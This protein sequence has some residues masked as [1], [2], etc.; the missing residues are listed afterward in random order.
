MSWPAAEDSGANAV[1]EAT[2]SVAMSLPCPPLLIPWRQC[3]QHVNNRATAWCQRKSLY[4]QD[5]LYVLKW[6]VQQ[7]RAVLITVIDKKQGM[8]M[9]LLQWLLTSYSHL[10]PLSYVLSRSGTTCHTARW[11]CIRSTWLQLKRCLTAAWFNGWLWHQLPWRPNH[12]F[13][14]ANAAV[15]LLEE[16]HQSATMKTSMAFGWGPTLSWNVSINNT[17]S[18]LIAI[19]PLTLAESNHHSVVKRVVSFC[20]GQKSDYV[21]FSLQF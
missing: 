17:P 7:Q 21:Y 5:C 1:Y 16:A 13:P 18:F 9:M 10:T 14:H 15:L 6:C 8:I 12:R 19:T 11:Q 4:W 2:V 20:L 3:A